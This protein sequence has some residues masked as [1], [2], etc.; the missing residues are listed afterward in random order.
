MKAEKSQITRLQYL[1]LND[2][3]IR[4]TIIGKNNK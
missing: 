1:E 4:K 2:S 3:E